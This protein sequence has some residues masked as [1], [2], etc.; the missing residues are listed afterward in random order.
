MSALLS[1]DAVAER[2]G[3]LPGWQRLGASIRKEFSFDGFPAAVAFV[4]RLVPP[5]EAADHHPD[6]E[7]HYRHVVVTYTTHSA[8]GLTAKDFEGALAAE[9]AA[10]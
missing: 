2:L 1:E 8:G 7:I 5:S 6:L 9:A 3:Q 10:G 4:T